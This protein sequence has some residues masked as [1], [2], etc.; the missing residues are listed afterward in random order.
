MGKPLVSESNESAQTKTPAFMT[1]RRRFVEGW[2]A[3]KDSNR[4]GTVPG[5]PDAQAVATADA[6]TAYQRSCM[7]SRLRSENDESAQT[8]TPAFMIERRRFVEEWWAVKDSNLGPI[9]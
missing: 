1:E 9:D 5:R 3:V 2:W 4:T 7:G 8:K 6:L